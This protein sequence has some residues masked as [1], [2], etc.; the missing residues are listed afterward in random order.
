[1]RLSLTHINNERG[2]IHIVAKAGVCLNNFVVLIGMDHGRR[3]SSKVHKNAG[4]R[5]QIAFPLT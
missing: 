1:M 3:H 4:T 2:T 5:R